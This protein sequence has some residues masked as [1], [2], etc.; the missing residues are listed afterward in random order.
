MSTQHDLTSTAVIGRIP[1]YN[2]KID[3]SHVF[4]NELLKGVTFIDLLPTSYK[5]IDVLGGKDRNFGS[6][7]T[8]ELP[9][10]IKSPALFQADA[11]DAGKM[12]GIF[13]GVLGRMESDFN[14]TSGFSAVDKIRIIAANDS[15]FTENFSNDFG[16]ENSIVT[17]SKSFLQLTGNEMSKPRLNDQ[18]KSTAVGTMANAISAGIK[19][20]MWAG[21]SL[22]GLNYADLIALAGNAASSIDGVSGSFGMNELLTGAFFGMNFA[23]PNQ[24]GGSSYNSTLTMFIKL[25]APVGTPACIKRNILEPLLYL[26]AAA[27]PLTYAGSM[28]GFPL[29]WNVQA[30]GITNFR[31]GGIANMSIIR[32]SFETTFNYRLQ[33]T[34]LDIRLTIVPLMSDFAV[35]TAA[36]TGKDASIYSEANSKYLGAQNPSDIKRGTLNAGS[37]FSQDQVV[38]I[39]L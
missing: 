6:I 15:T 7:F 1:G 24:W 30:H 18:G 2:S 38:T 14:L 20:A 25:V 16:Q 28:Y 31:L 36:N 5:L 39:K 32:G 4:A 10:L 8:K 23:A 12:L 27:S 26:L 13:R 33:P 37:G 3:T 19:G 17:S 34:V 11:D 22:K 29:M 21:R 35:Q 9:N